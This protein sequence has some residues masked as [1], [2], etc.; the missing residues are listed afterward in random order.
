MQIP[1]VTHPKWAKLISGELKCNFEL[2]SV[3]ILLGRLVTN[4]KNTPTEAVLNECINEARNF[5]EKNQR[6]PKAEKD[7]MEI[8]K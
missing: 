3:K 7:L 4:Y 2:L 1:S 5:F 6:L 8:F